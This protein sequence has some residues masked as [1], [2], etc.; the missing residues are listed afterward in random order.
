MNQV[1]GRH[2]LDAE[3]VTFVGRTELLAEV[4]RQLQ[5]RRVVTLLGLGGI[6]KTT[7]SRR[8][9]SD[10]APAF[11]DGVALIDLTGLSSWDQVL[12]KVAEELGIPDNS[13][14]GPLVTRLIVELR[15][16]QRLLVLDNCERVTAIVARLARTLLQAAPQLRILTTSRKPLKIPGEHQILVGPMGLDESFALLQDRGAAVNADWN[17][18]LRDNG[19]LPPADR[20]AALE[21]CDLLEG[22][23]LST[24]LAAG[25]LGVMTVQEAV[26]SLAQSRPDDGQPR[27][28]GVAA[29][30]RLGLLQGDQQFEQQHHRSLRA[31]F[32]L[33]YKL[34]SVTAQ[35]ALGLIWVFDGGFDLQAA[36]TVCAR[37]GIQEE[38]M[39]DVLSTLVH[40]SLLQR[41]T[42]QE[43]TWYTM[44]ETIREYGAQLLDDAEVGALEQAHADFVAEMVDIATLKWYSSDELLWIRRLQR[45][46]LNIL[47]ALNYLLDQEEQ[48]PRGQLLALGA[49]R[50]RY[51][52]YG[53]QLN[54]ARR[55]LNS[56]L[57]AQPGQRSE[58]Q[59]MALSM[60]AYLAF[61]QGEPGRGLPILANARESALQLGIDEQGFPPLLFAMATQRWLNESD[62]AVAATATQL[63]YLAAELSLAVGFKGDWIMGRLFGAASEAFYGDA[64]SAL[65]DAAALLAEAESVG[66]PWLV[67]WALWVFAVAEMLH[68]DALRAICLVQK[69]LRMQYDMGE[70]WGQGWGLLVRAW[71]AVMQDDF[72]LAGLVV[73][74][75]LARLEFTRSNLDGLTS[76][77][78]VHKRLEQRARGELGDEE[79]EIQ[80]ALGRGKSYDEMVDIALE[81]VTR[82][83][84]EDIQ[85]T[86]DELT[87]R[88]K[89]VAAL[90]RKGLRNREIAAH[91][92]ISERT[93]ETHVSRVLK[94]L[95]LTS[96]V[97]LAITMT[98]A[99]ASPETTD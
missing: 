44:L 24:E 1:R 81:P 76:F 40:N 69:S 72:E 78:R 85:P 25:Q 87:S 18:A 6:G 84:R 59:V 58:L 10:A 56:A 54:G 14:D 79:W 64:A 34:L 28:V 90:V 26:A 83:V 66:A 2:A 60:G 43:T 21:L 35:R 5:R 75:A 91:L 8:A 30:S 53:G 39:L 89:E 20:A 42:R 65:A 97:Q 49:V 99:P 36:Q 94:K 96:R 82:A 68:G 74:G 88:E 51:Q 48:I 41:E 11:H 92:G 13:A 70:S 17:A 19:E 27:R 55:L 86:A 37:F 4:L 63:F 9:A 45:Q 77:K 32:D 12:S 62:E 80:I 22:I 31:S 38:Q 33:S 7:L 16:Q 23:P 98:S 15:D 29:A 71:L 47:A 61:A 67:S 93:A 73:G 3:L 95:G 50:T 46:N 52:I 57:D